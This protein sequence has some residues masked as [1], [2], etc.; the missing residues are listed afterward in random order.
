M[1]G[2]LYAFDMLAPELSGA[3][4]DAFV[5][6]FALPA[7]IRSRNHYVGDANQQA[8]VDAVALYAG[9]AARNWPLVAFATSSEHGIPAILEWTFADDGR[10]IRDNYQTYAL[11]ALFFNAE[12]LYHRGVDLYGPYRNRWEAAASWRGR[13][14]FEDA[15]FWQFVKANRTGT[16]AELPAPRRLTAEP[17]GTGRVVLRWIDPS[18]SEAWFIIE[19]STGSGAGFQEVGRSSGTWPAFEDACPQRGTAY[20]YRI[21]GENYRASASEPSNVASATCP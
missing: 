21:R 4:R 18:D 5:A 10:H 15:Y 1:A 11:R 3:E 14:P 6:G 20:S 7:G 13:R 16:T 2:I 9:L 17:A 12:L 19:R 8:T